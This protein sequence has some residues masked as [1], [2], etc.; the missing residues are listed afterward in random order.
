MVNFQTIRESDESSGIE[1]DVTVSGETGDIDIDASIDA[2]T[3][4]TAGGDTAIIR[5][6]GTTLTVAQLDLEFNVPNNRLS[7]LRNSL[8]DIPDRIS[9]QFGVNP[10]IARGQLEVLR[11][12]IGGDRLQG[13]YTD[14]VRDVNDT[15][16]EELGLS[17]NITDLP[18]TFDFD[19]RFTPLVA[20]DRI[21]NQL[22]SIPVTVSVA[23][24]SFF[25][26]F[27]GLPSVTIELPPEAFVEPRPTTDFDFCLDPRAQIAELEELTRGAA[28]RAR[29]SLNEL[30]GVRDEV[31]NRIG[32]VDLSTSQFRN[33]VTEFRNNI[34]SQQQLSQF[35]DRVEEWQNRVDEIS[36]NPLPDGESLRDIL[37][38]RIPD[39]DIPT[40]CIDELRDRLNSL[41][42][43]VQEAR[44]LSVQIN[45]LK[46]RLRDR[47]NVIS[48]LID[49]I[50]DRLGNCADPSVTPSSLQN[51]IESFTS[52]ADRF[53]QVSSFRTENRFQ[54][55]LDTSDE[56]RDRVQRSVD[57][58]D[59]IQQWL[60][61]IDSAR[62][63][64]Q[65]VGT[66]GIQCSNE[67]AR[68]SSDIDS[69]I[70]N[71]REFERIRE[72]ERTQDRFSELTNRGESLQSRIRRE[73][74]EQECIQ[75]FE[76]RI[77]QTLSDVEQT[78]AR[79]EAVIP[80][81]QQYSSIDDQI[82]EFENM[83]A[84]LSVPVQ[85]QRQQ[86]V[87]SEGLDLIEQIEQNVEPGRCREEFVT[88]ARGASNRVRS[89]TEQVSVTRVEEAQDQAQETLQ[90]LL[91]QIQQIQVRRGS[92]RVRNRD[93]IL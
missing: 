44:D 10:D 16:R 60:D 89:L 45:N 7:S 82:D 19:V 14:Q 51:S 50:S 35:E 83:V 80:C 85:P 32:S 68:L 34:R 2:A 28:D 86:E 55:L 67:Y 24:D 53:V 70:S 57:Q 69:F 22:P 91:D 73:V 46:S 84:Q 21:L 81:G 1:L 66:Q 64:I 78:G 4:I 23:S 3:E 9:D 75:Q 36:V 77:D 42:N 88:R 47:L 72:I 58:S 41:R 90:Q 56:L 33:R 30:Q 52:D 74:D 17:R 15:I 49:G 48:S 87:A 11:S 61:Q 76:D 39:I 37:V 65:R 13:D 38:N 62:N 12:Q 43:R 25:S 92:G 6:G 26:R 63:R 18:A 54:N 71:I 29:N 27:V 79:R 59:C 40:P 20:T 31:E 93:S 5:P 8:Q